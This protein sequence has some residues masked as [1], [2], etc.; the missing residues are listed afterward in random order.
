[1]VA[2]RAMKQFEIRADYNGE[3]IVVYQAYRPAIADA[4][5][6]AQRAEL[7]RHAASTVVA[8]GAKSF[9]LAGHPRRR[10]ASS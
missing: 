4:A 9:H 5:V 3:T 6:A 1:M 8:S 7:V 10:I 2:P